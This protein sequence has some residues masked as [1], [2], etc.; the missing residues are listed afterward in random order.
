MAG[1]IRVANYGKVQI[2]GI[3]KKA[4]F[5]PMTALSPEILCCFIGLFYV[6]NRAYWPD[7]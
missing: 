2:G 5:Y 4:I 6:D 3:A 7:E 1:N